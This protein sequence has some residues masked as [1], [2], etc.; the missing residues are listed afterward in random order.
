LEEKKI[1]MSSLEGHVADLRD[2]MDRSR[3]MQTLKM[4]NLKNSLREAEF[5]LSEAEF[6]LSDTEFKLSDTDKK[7][8][9]ASKAMPD[10]GKERLKYEKALEM[11]SDKC[12]GFDAMA[13]KNMQ[14]R[15]LYQT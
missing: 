14:L 1:E 13:V 8:A 10:A 7:I 6:K 9:N 5:K 15:E 3:K 2:E 4:Q 11:A 12:E